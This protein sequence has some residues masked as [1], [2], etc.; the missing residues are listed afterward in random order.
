M[1]RSC[2]YLNDIGRMHLKRAVLYR[3]MISK[4]LQSADYIS[5]K[6][7]GHAYG[8]SQVKFQLHSSIIS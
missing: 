3:S 6:S 5:A 4:H 1:F 2:N 7:S 8:S